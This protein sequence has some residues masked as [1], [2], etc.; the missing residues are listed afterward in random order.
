MKDEFNF[1]T[2]KFHQIVPFVFNPELYKKML[3]ESER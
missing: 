3:K 1:V 2:N